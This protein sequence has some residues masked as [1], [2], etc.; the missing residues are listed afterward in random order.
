MNGPAKRRSSRRTLAALL[1]LLAVA[2][3]GAAF[4][5]QKITSMLRVEQMRAVFEREMSAAFGLEVRIGPEFD[6]D[7]LPVP[8][9]RLANLVVVNAPGHRSPH[10]L[11][12][13]SVELE[14]APLELL[15]G[16]LEIDELEMID[17]EVHVE[18]G[19]VPDLPGDLST[20]ADESADETLPVRLRS[21]RLEDARLSYDPGGG[22][23]W[24]VQLDELDMAAK[25]VGE[26]MQLRLRGSI[27]GSHFDIAGS[28]GPVTELFKPTRPFPLALRGRLFEAE[29]E[30]QGTIDTP[31]KLQGVDLAVSGRIP[32]P[33]SLPG[34]VGGRVPDIGP[35]AIAGRLV[36]EGGAFSLRS[37]R[38]TAERGDPLRA[39]MQGSIRDVRGFLGIDLTLDAELADLQ[40]LEPFLER[41][42]PSLAPLQL[43]AKLSDADGS[44]GV[45]GTLRGGSDDGPLFVE[46]SGHQDDLTAVRGIDVAIRARAA[47]LSVVGG[48]LQKGEELPPIGPVVARARLRDHRG[49]VG[50]EEIEVELGR[51]DAVWAQGGGSIQDLLAR[52][53][54]DVEAE[55]GVGDLRQLGAVVGGEPPDVGPIRGKLHLADRDGS[56][57]IERF[58]A[59]GGKVGLFEIE[60]SGAFEDLLE[61][62]QIQVNARLS[63]RDLAVVGAVFGR[64]LPAIAPVE[65]SGTVRGSNESIS[66]QGYALLGET[67]LE[68]SWS[69]SLVEGRRPRLRA[70][71]RSA[72]VRLRDLG[73]EPQDSDAEEAGQ[74]AGPWWKGQQLL[75]FELLRRVD[76]ELDAVAARVTGRGG[77]DVQD[78]HAALGLEADRLEVRDLTGRYESGQ[79]RARLVADSAP[80]SPEVWVQADVRGMNLEKLASQLVE[81]PSA[82]GVLDLSMD[83]RSHGRS[84]DELRSNLAGEFGV[85][86]RNW[87][88]VTDY[89]KRVVK[90]LAS[91]I[92]P[93]L[94]AKPRELACF[95]GAFDVVEGRAETRGRGM[96]LHDDDVTVWGKGYVD[97]GRDKVKLNLVP[98]VHD[99]GLLSMAAE[100]KIRGSLLEPTYRTEPLSLATSAA[101]GFLHNALRPGSRVLGLFLSPKEKPANPCDMELPPSGL[102]RPQSS[103]G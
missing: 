48:L 56:L 57:G 4:V 67:R 22:K 55:F 51:R 87:Q 31:L 98:E 50:L 44:L 101:R 93:D 12:A 28:H 21:L 99:P 59:H 80:E 43:E 72:H 2:A 32:D 94:Q 54:V 78:A 90:D 52:K 53:G 25:R 95:V 81:D 79:V 9:F 11:D 17:A 27:E 41:P 77:L 10:L 20:L 30:V 13:H 89:A 70:H 85:R 88:L 16:R 84:L 60:A 46:I 37:L 18:P 66:S 82:A 58:E 34:E 26:P 92:L 33:G 100:V 36:E 6:F 103:D 73:I 14:L 35:I 75:P 64:D 7:L 71:V 68:G 45:E 61:R 65:L 97:L 96:I 76:L 1:G 86:V 24:S 63:G 15:F 69:G 83:L 19:G 3:A 42:L 39:D 5:A 40:L 91:A 62:D 102:P 29:L 74:D 23:V 49:A 38:L 8:R 47:D